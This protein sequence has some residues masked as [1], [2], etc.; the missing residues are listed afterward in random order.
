MSGG[1]ASAP[2]GALASRQADGARAARNN[3]RV[4]LKPVHR[5][6][7]VRKMTPW[8]TFGSPTGMARADRRG[9]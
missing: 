6:R 4:M 9:R 7:L 3:G 1:S 5:L 2:S 8:G